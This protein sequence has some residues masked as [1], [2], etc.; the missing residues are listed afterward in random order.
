MSTLNMLLW[1][2]KKTLSGYP[3]VSGAM[4]LFYKPILSIGKKKIKIKKNSF[5]H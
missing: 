4:I 3:F 2:N 1:R 5:I